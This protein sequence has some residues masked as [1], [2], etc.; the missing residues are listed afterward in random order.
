[1]I[2]VW[3][4]LSGI[5][6]KLGGKLDVFGRP[7]EF[8]GVEIPADEGRYGR[9]RND[10][11]FRFA[12]RQ[13]SMDV[14]FY[15]TGFANDSA[16]GTGEGFIH[17]IPPNPLREGEIPRIILLL[18]I[19]KGKQERRSRCQE[20]GRVDRRYQLVH[21]GEHIRAVAGKYARAQKPE[22][23]SDCRRQSADRQT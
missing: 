23:R 4:K 16:G 18:K 3:K 7:L 8:R 9:R 13:E 19:M 17:E 6:K 1:M 10:A 11:D 22:Y 14:A 15:M 21:P 2:L 20:A 5:E 12:D